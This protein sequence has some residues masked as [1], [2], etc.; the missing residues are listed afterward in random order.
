M[1]NLLLLPALFLST[2][3]CIAQKNSPVIRL[4]LY[5]NIEQS[6]F[7][8]RKTVA[9]QTFTTNQNTY[10]FGHFSLA[11]SFSGKKYSQE[12]ELSRLTIGKKEDIRIL[13]GPDN[14]LAV[15]ISGETKTAIDLRIRYEFNYAFNTAF[16]R[17]IPQIGI[18]TQPYF[19]SDKTTPKTSGFYPSKRIIAGNSVYFT[20]R[21]VINMNKKLFFD[22]NMPVGILDAF[23]ISETES[24]PALPLVETK[25][26]T[27]TTKFFRNW[28]QFRVGI[29]VDLAHE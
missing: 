4:K 25:S 16:N 12:I 18:G 7:N 5:G 20:P 1:K 6:G 28:F 15:P 13:N 11:I 26:S 8:Y 21:I 24:D 29:G 2:L 17:I 27:F 19:I 14:N 23:Y 3:P 10:S 9:Q 22:I